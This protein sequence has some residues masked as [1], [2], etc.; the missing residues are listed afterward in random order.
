LGYFKA[1]AVR[2]T[3]CKAACLFLF[4]VS[5]SVWAQPDL[6]SSEANGQILVEPGT[7]TSIYHLEDITPDG[8]Y[9]LF[10]SRETCTLYRKNRRTGE[11]L[12]V[13]ENTR[14]DSTDGSGYSWCNG[15]GISANGNLVAASPTQNLGEP[16]LISTDPHRGEL[17]SFGNVVVVARKNITT[18]ELAEVTREYT[19][20]ANDIARIQLG[21]GCCYANQFRELST[22]GDTALI[23]D[24]V[25]AIGF[26]QPLINPTSYSTVKIDAQT[27]T[28]VR[29]PLDA[30][31]DFQPVISQA[32]MS[33]NGAQLLLHVATVIP[34][35]L[36]DPRI[37]QD[38]PTGPDAVII[39]GQLGRCD[40]IGTPP[41]DCSPT[42]ES[43]WCYGYTPIQQ[44]DQLLLYDTATRATRIV[45]TR[46]IDSALQ[47]G[48]I[49][50]SGDGNFGF[51]VLAP[52]NCPVVNG[53]APLPGPLSDAGLPGPLPYPGW[54]GAEEEAGA[55]L[56]RLPLNVGVAP[57]VAA[58][59]SVCDST[60]APTT[61]Q[62]IFLS[63]S[64]DGARVLIETGARAF[65]LNLPPQGDCT[66]F[67]DPTYCERDANLGDYFGNEGPV[68]NP[69]ATPARWYLTDIAAG[70]SEL[71]SIFDGTMIAA[72]PALLAG[73]GAEWAFSTTRSFGA[74]VEANDIV[75]GAVY[76]DSAGK[77]LNLAVLT[78]RA[79]RQ[80]GD[81][82]VRLKTIVSNYGDTAANLVIIDFKIGSRGRAAIL[83][84]PVVT[85]DYGDCQVH[86][87]TYSGNKA[88]FEID[89]G[90]LQ[91]Q[92]NRYVL[93][94]AIGLL[95]AGQ[96]ITLNWQIDSASRTPIQIRSHVAGNEADSRQR[97]NTRWIVLGA[98]R[99][100]S[101]R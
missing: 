16:E 39:C 23:A 68:I 41:E 46:D 100:R 50:M 70:H 30:N 58:V 4:T 91:Q 65:Y 26:G 36:P 1:S 88:V 99:G 22:D 71:V 57:E 32:T 21:N 25:T 15:A 2:L 31:L 89:G 98:G 56:K 81:T 18:G 3:A 83:I 17:Y 19:G 77:D 95:G 97:N 53:P 59:S 35:Q 20:N 94:C 13:L 67:Y 37:Q 43:W 66:I 11:L 101:Q 45:Y 51:F 8:R 61:N 62:C 48:A 84:D 72:G 87:N 33:S 92:G 64:D 78:R 5:T 28:A 54:C 90:E 60:D 24:I 86:D 9:A 49:A 75:D 29:L 93:R 40:D 10:S 85:L 76:A 63:A 69:F 6:V 82:G 79:P 27:I 80:S 52:A 14:A 55:G 12:T 38:G 47:L 74:F 96:S 44:L 34:N 7:L 42:D 73:N